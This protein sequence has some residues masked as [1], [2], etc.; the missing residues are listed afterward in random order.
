MEEIKVKLKKFSSV[1]YVISKIGFVMSIVGICL[2]G[3]GIII[4]LATSDLDPTTAAGSV[5][6]HWV[7][8]DTSGFTVPDFYGELS[9]DI[10]SM[11]F[12]ISVCSISMRLFKNMRDNYTPFTMEN[13]ELFKKLA[14][15]MIVASIVPPIIGQSIGSSVASMMDVAYEGSY[16]SGFSLIAVLI[17]FFISVVFRYGCQLQQEVDETL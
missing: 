3:L 6:I 12:F 5:T 10:A 16:G 7:P 8:I 4:Q 9:Y 15:I 13:A 1:I 11:A 14:I 17:M 2:A